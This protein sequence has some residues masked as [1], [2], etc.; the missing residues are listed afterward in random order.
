MMTALR[1]PLF[2]IPL[3]N[4]IQAKYQSIKKSEP[5][6]TAEPQKVVKKNNNHSAVN[7]MPY[8]RVPVQ[9][10][11]NCYSFGASGYA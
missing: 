8:R 7:N 5:A 3:P 9:T 10:G 2:T 11:L 4:L 6:K 1:Q